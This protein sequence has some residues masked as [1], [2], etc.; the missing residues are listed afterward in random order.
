MSHSHKGTVDAGL[1]DGERTL[2]EEWLNVWAHSAFLSQEICRVFFTALDT[3]PQEIQDV[4]SSTACYQRNAR[5]E[6][7]N[8]FK[9]VLALCKQLGSTALFHHLNL[10]KHQVTGLDFLDIVQEVNVCIFY[11][12]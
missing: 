11:S 8:R 6:V 4:S 12:F 10:S 7:Q 2:I 1:T 9:K 5:N 3:S